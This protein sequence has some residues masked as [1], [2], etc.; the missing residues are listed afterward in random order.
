MVL[1]KHQNDLKLRFGA[2]TTKQT[3]TVHGYIKELAQ[4][5]G[6]EAV[7]RLKA[8]TN[9]KGQPPIAKIIPYKS[10]NLPERELILPDEVNKLKDLSKPIGVHVINNFSMSLDNLPR[11]LNNSVENKKN[12]KKTA[13]RI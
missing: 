7:E 2:V 12:N 10:S 6:P 1:Q 5:A 11:P 13:V 4:L 8:T 9:K 3:Q